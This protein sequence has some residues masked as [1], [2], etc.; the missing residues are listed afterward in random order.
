MSGAWGSDKG[1]CPLGSRDEGSFVTVKL[2]P[3]PFL[4]EVPFNHGTLDLLIGVTSFSLQLRHVFPGSWFPS[5]PSRGG[6]QIYQNAQE[7]CVSKIVQGSSLV[8]NA[9]T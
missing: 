9:P 4:G 8:S 6:T 3:P 1:L 7:R 5:V 2:D